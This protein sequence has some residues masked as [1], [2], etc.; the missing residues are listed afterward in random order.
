MKH[1]DNQTYLTEAEAAQLLSMSE[2]DFFTLTLEGGRPTHL[3]EDGQ[4]LYLKAAIEGMR[5]EADA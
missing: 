2:E 4:V 1:I 5:E 3:I